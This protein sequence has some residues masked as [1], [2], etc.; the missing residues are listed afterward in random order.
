VGGSR[1]EPRLAIAVGMVLRGEI[2]RAG[3]F[4]PEGCIVPDAFFERYQRYCENLNDAGGLLYDV[5][6]RLR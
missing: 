2:T 5:H 1:N 4:A 3:V 6:Q